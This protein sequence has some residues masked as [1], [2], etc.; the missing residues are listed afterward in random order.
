MGT[1]ESLREI[2]HNELRTALRLLAPPFLSY[3]TRRNRV[4]TI[5]LSMNHMYPERLACTTDLA[6]CLHGNS[7]NLHGVLS[8]NDPP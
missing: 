7:P 1:C 4:Q 6:C 2:H 3:G 5:I 8:N